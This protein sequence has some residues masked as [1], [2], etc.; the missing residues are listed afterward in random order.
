[1]ATRVRGKRI[2]RL[3]KMERVEA[4]FGNERWR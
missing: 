3:G 4:P 1:M 2:E